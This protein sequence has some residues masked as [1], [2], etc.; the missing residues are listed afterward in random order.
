[1]LTTTVATTTPTLRILTSKMVVTTRVTKATKMA[2]TMINTTSKE[3]LVSNNIKVKG[4]DVV[5]TPKKTLRPSVIS[6]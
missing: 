2:T 3:L 6:P 4:E 1:M 5:T